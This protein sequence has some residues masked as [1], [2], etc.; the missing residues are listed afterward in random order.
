MNVG[1]EAMRFLGRNTPFSSLW[2][3]RLGFE[4]IFLNTLQDLADPEA[5]ASRR[6]RIQ[7][8]KRDYGNEFFWWPGELAPNQP[9]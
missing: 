9:E 6:R 8:Q 1:R 2:Y 7:S 5:A 3:L 4:R